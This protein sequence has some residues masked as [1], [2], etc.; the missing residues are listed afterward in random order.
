MKILIT[1]SDGMIGWHTRCFFHRSK[2]ATFIPCN[3]EQFADD[4]YLANAV[5]SCDAVIHLAGANRGEPGIVAQTNC[6]LANRLVQ[7]LKSTR[8]KPHVLFSNSTHVDSNTPYG[9]SK[10]ECGDRF[11]KW[12]GDCS[13]S[14]TDLVLPHIFGEH[15]KPFYNSVVSTFACQ[16]V[17]GDK[18]AV[19]SD[20]DLCLLHAGDVA[21]TFWEHLLSK[22]N[23]QVRPAGT[24]MKVT[25]LLDTLSRFWESY[26]GGVIPSLTSKLETQLFNTIRSMLESEQRVI[27]LKVNADERGYLFEA[28]RENTGGQVFYSTT[29]PGITRGNHFHTRKIERFLVVSGEAEIKLRRVLTDDVIV[30]QVSGNRPQAIDMPTLHT[31]S[32]T[33]V[34]DSELRTLFWCNEHFNS[35][36]PDTFFETV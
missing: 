32:I 5:A 21:E 33:N 25:C 34:G 27:N 1:G 11:R 6:H 16:L 18:P 26:S 15:G 29:K 8:A 35:S 24:P 9:E 2:E 14:F 4:I 31:H 3:R 12:A 23:A 7:I 28:V 17:R 36:D 19:L 10:R 22:T 20:G 30:Y 13:A